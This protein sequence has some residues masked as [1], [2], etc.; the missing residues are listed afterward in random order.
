MKQ[1]K[2]FLTFADSRM[3]ESIER[4]CRQAWAMNVYDTVFAWNEN[5]LTPAF[6]EKYK[7]HLKAGTRGYGYWVWK[8][9]I[10]RQALTRIDENDILHYADVGCHLNPRG[11]G[12]LEEYF[13][14]AASSETGILGF[15]SA[16]LKDYMWTKGDLIDYL[17]VRDNANIIRSGTVVGT[18][19][20]IRKTPFSHAFVAR[21]QGIFDTNF[22]LIDDTP[23]QAPNFEGFIEHR[24]DQ[25]AFSILAKLSHTPTVSHAENY[26]ANKNPDGTPDW[27]SLQDFPVLAMRDK[28]KK[29]SLPKRLLICMLK[30][31]S[32]LIF[33]PKYRKM[34]RNIR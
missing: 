16:E 9:E 27:T 2:I 5:D 8:P 32:F 34:V 30:R 19:F 28:T 17:Q 4:I 10:V 12:R 24:H 15:Q 33:L 14:I 7:K 6:R 31:F 29:R 26:P 25:S 22:S 1:K 11:R 3:Q 13:K 23:S 18:S 20:F 21:W